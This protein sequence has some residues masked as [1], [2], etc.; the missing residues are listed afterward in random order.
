DRLQDPDV[1]AAL[2]VGM[3]LVYNTVLISIL[4]RRRDVG[5]LK[6][7]GAS[8]RQIFFAFLGEVLLFGAIGAALGIALGDGLARAILGLVG[9]T[10]NS[11]YVTSQPEAVTLTS[12]VVVLVV[13]VGVALSLASAVQPSLEAA[14][15]R[16]LI[17]IRGGQALS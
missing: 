17:M 1:A 16:P 5:I 8:P 7:I 13:V 6:T 12:F 9:R 3:Y 14:Q 15:I 11:L 10:I 4:R 2:L